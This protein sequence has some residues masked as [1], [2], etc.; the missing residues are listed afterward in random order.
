MLLSAHVSDRGKWRSNE[1]Y[2]RQVL[3]HALQSAPRGL[4]ENSHEKD[5]SDE[6]RVRRGRQDK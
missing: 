2:K 3:T 6:E 4:E 1:E 5:K